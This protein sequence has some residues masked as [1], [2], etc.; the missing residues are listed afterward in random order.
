M[1]RY[2]GRSRVACEVPDVDIDVPTRALRLNNPIKRVRRKSGRSGLVR[3]P[4]RASFGIARRID[5]DHGQN[6][7]VYVM[8]ERFW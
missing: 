6:V 3:E 1:Y 4:A 7:C 5:V 8:K 2:R